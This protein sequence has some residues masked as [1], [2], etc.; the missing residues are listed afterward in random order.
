LLALALLLSAA[1][2]GLIAACLSTRVRDLLFLM[3]VFLSAVTERVDV[4]FVSRDWYRGS[5]R[6]FEV[7]L[8]DVLSFCLLV[9]ALVVPRRGEKRW[10]WPAS[11]GGMLIFLAYA[12]FCTALTDPKLFS[13]FELSKMVRGIVIFLA[14]ASFV[15]GERELK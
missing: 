10:F 6:G 7:S 15:R 14:A 12:A 8:V 3:L 2:G 1:T 13:L 9:S 11:L 5:T 4:N